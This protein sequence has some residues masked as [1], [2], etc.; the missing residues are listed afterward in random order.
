MPMTHVLLRARRRYP[1]VDFEEV[2][3]VQ[4]LVTAALLAV[5]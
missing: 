4:I 3:D 2:Y 1:F 5:P